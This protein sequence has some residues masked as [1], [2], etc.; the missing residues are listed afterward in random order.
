MHSRIHSIWALTSGSQ[1]GV[2]ND[3]VY[4]KTTCF[5][6]F[7]FL[8]ATEPQKTK[9][10][11]L[12][13]QID[14][15]RKRQQEQHPNLTLTG[16]YNVLEKLRKLDGGYETEPLTAKEKTIHEKGLVAI[17][18][19]LHDELDTA[20][21]DAY[22]WSDLAPKLV[23][24]PG[25]TTPWPDKPDE[26][27]EAEE[28]LLQRLVDLNTQRAA[29]EQRGIIHWLRPEYQNP[30]QGRATAQTQGKL[31]VPAIQE[32]VEKS[33]PTW[34]KSIQE[35]VQALR[36]ALQQQPEPTTAEQLARSFKKARTDRVEDL[37][38]TLTSLGQARKLDNR[39]F[40]R[41]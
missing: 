23:G 31:E 34:P 4:N 10:G 5:E 22:G 13:E 15:H 20:V 14:A 26:Q 11:D 30:E 19:Q 8:E 25:A 39:L 40:V 32:E 18:R 29:E 41:S 6:A 38:E 27:A 28:E 9:I 33:K 2:E 16:I 24:R 21:F 3:P 1:L 37:L 35:Q 12:A 36:D 7:P 17:L